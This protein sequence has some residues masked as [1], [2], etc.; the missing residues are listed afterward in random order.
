MT[1][2]IFAHSGRKYLTRLSNLVCTPWH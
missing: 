1:T 2:T